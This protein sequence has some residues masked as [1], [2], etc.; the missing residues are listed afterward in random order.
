MLKH[1]EQ[2]L[3]YGFNNFVFKSNIF[4]FYILYVEKNME[5][6]KK[7][8][9]FRF[10]NTILVYKNTHNCIMCRIPLI[11]NNTST[12]Q[13]IYLSRHILLKLNTHN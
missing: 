12:T 5:I 3:F 8:E 11:Y 4:Y 6:P 7:S 2:I 1:N 9:Y 13:N 10:F